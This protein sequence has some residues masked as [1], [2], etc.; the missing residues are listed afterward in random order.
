MVGAGRE[1]LEND[2]AGAE[3]EAV[4]GERTVLRKAEAR[5]EVRTCK[6]SSTKS[7]AN[8][9]L[10]AVRL[11]YHKQTRCSASL[12]SQ[13]QI[14][15]PLSMELARLMRSQVPRRQPESLE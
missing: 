2:G 5:G 14:H 12:R 10:F 7:W 6:G 1:R 13:T 9:R 3:D 4:D 15:S 11:K 8:V